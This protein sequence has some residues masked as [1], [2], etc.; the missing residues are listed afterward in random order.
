M[1]GEP[2]KHCRRSEGQ[3][4]GLQPA[5]GNEHGGLGL[6]PPFKLKRRASGPACTRGQ[7]VRPEDGGRA[8]VMPE[9]RFERMERR[10]E[11]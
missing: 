5:Y 8:R 3:G 11:A 7:S 4:G 1:P 6:P 9:Y 2:K 10:S